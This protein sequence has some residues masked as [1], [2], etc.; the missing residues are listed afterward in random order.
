MAHGGQILVSIDVSVT[1]LGSL[2]V[3]DLG[4]HVLLT[5]KKKKNEGAV[6]KGVV[7]LI[8]SALTYDYSSCRPAIENEKNADIQ[9]KGSQFPPV[10]SMKRLSTSNHEAS[11]ADITV[12]MSFVYISEIEKLFDDA[13]AALAKQIGALLVDAPGGG[14]QSKKCMLAFS[15]P[16]PFHLVRLCKSTCTTSR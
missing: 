8:P 12:T 10:L 15:S 5:G 4:T 11:Y 13:S 6:A 2:Q 14:Y 1:K 9:V 7:Q 16:T 3:I